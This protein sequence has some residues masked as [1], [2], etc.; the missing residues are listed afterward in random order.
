[1]MNNQLLQYMRFH[2]D[3]YIM[4]SRYP[5]KIKDLQHIY[6][7]ETNQTFISKVEKVAMIVKML[8]MLM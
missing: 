2:P 8:D 6:N 7:E 1:M 4:I 5:E 3:W